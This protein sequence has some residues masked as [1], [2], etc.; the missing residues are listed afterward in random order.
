MRLLL[1]ALLAAS[2]SVTPVL[3]SEDNPSF[4]KVYQAFQTAS[5]NKEV[6]KAL[7]LSEQALSLGEKQFGEDSENTAML[8]YTYANMLAINKHHEQALSVYDDVYDAYENLYGEDAEQMIQLAM[9]VITYYNAMPHHVKI[10]E[11]NQVDKYF[12]NLLDALEDNQTLQDKQRAALYHEAMMTISKTGNI[13]LRAMELNSFAKRGV[14]LIEAAWGSEDVR[15]VEAKFLQA[16]IYELND[17]DSHAID[18][19]EE[20]AEIL[21]SRVAFSHPYA[22]ASHA[23]LV[24]LLESRGESERATKH[25]IAIGKMSPWDPNQEQEPLYRKNPDYPMSYARRGREGWV[26]LSFDISEYG[27]VENITV[28]ESNGGALFANEGL[29]ALEQWRY[30]PKFENG[31]PVVAKELVVQLDFELM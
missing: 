16:R 17:K 15:T 31:K 25:C 8:R 13:P 28:L 21:D 14:E 9:S 22:L 23:K 6:T 24:S 10:D 20:V 12:D 19:Y 30:A 7:R 1:P 11:I 18:R 2:L 3:A 27:F 5:A 29:K 26:R 4:S